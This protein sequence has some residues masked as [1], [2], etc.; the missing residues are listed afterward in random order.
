MK[1]TE[2]Y[3]N[4]Y[5]ADFHYELTREQLEQDW[6]LDDEP[7]YKAKDCFCFHTADKYWLEVGRTEIAEAFENCEESAIANMSKDYLEFFAEGISD[8][9]FNK[10]IKQDI[11]ETFKPSKTLEEIGREDFEES[12][13]Y[14]GVQHEKKV[15][16]AACQK[17]IDAFYESKFDPSIDYMKIFKEN[18]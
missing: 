18:L 10:F 7:Y 13:F 17:V 9:D 3:I 14:A 16:I 6:I 5:L 15:A 1:L 4:K 11:E 2:K 12:G 8:E